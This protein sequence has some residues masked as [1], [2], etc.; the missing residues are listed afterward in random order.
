MSSQN[1]LVT[2]GTGWSPEALRMYCRAKASSQ[3]GEERKIWDGREQ[4]LPSP[5]AMG[6]NG[7]AH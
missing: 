5:E 1:K 6:M 2:I 4:T 3:R 7:Q